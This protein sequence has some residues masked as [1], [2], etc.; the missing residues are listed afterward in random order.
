M[1]EKTSD[2]HS[3]LWFVS[4][5]LGVLELELYAG[6]RRPRIQMG[7]QRSSCDPFSF[8]IH[9]PL[10]PIG[11]LSMVLLSTMRSLQQTLA[12]VLFPLR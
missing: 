12:A 8:V 2:A 11:Y 6:A 1:R 10:L 9:L 7:C 4:S 3:V 5:S